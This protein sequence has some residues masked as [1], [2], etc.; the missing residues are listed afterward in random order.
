MPSHQPTSY[1]LRCHLDLSEVIVEH[2]RYIFCN[3]LQVLHGGQHAAHL[4]T[5]VVHIRSKISKQRIRLIKK[6]I[7]NFLIKTISNGWI[8]TLF[9]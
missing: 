8:N 9:G 7:H 3:E 6:S 5:Y 1:Y 4:I 2:F